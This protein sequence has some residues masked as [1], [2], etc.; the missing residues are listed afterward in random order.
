MLYGLLMFLLVAPGCTEKGSDDNPGEQGSSVIAPSG[1]DVARRACVFRTGFRMP[2]QS[3]VDRY[4]VVWEAPGKDSSDSMPTGNG[5]IGLNVWVEEDGDLLFYVGKTDA[6]SENGRLL[7][8]GRVRVRLTPNPFV[9]GAAFKQELRLR[10]GEIAI[11]GGEGDKMVFVRVWADANHPVVH[12]EARGESPFDMQVGLET[13]RNEARELKDKESHSA[14]G[15]LGGP[16]PVIVEPDVIMAGQ[17]NRIVWYHRN[18]RSLW[19]DNMSLQSLNHLT[20]TLSDPLLH[21]TFGAAIEGEG[22]RSVD[23]KTLR[24]ARAAKTFA[25]AVYPLT[26]QADSVAQWVERLD[27]QVKEIKRLDRRMSRAAHR[28]WWDRYWQR[29]WIYARGSK[30]AEA[31]TR[32][33]ALQRYINACQGRGAQ[34]IKFNGGIFNVDLAKPIPRKKLPAGL[35]ADF[36]PWGGCYW[37]QN[38][39][40]PY[41]AMLASGDFDLMQPL[42][43]MYR[44]ALPLARERTKTW[45]DHEGVFFPETMHFWGMHCNSNYGWDR[46]GKPDGLTDNTFIRYYWQGGLEFS[47]MLLDYFD[48]TQDMGFAQ[49]TMMPLVSEVITFYDQHWKRDESGKI[50]FDPAGALETYHSAVNPLPEI[51]GIEQVAKRL[52]A[53]P[54]SLTTDTQ[55]KQWRRLIEE[56]PAVPMRELDGQKVLD[57][58]ESFE[59]KLRNDENIGLYAIFPYRMYGL[60]KP[61]FDLAKRS[62]THRMCRK[63]GGYEY[64]GVMAACVGVTEDAVENVVT[65]FTSKHHDFRF[66]AFWSSTY[67]D[68]IPDQPQGGVTMTTLQL[69]LMQ[70]QG[71]KIMLLPAWP[72]E[73]DV[74]FKLYAPYQTVV[75]GKYSNGK[76]FVTKVQPQ[77]R[78]GDLVSPVYEMECSQ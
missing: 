31:V 3:P 15:L 53:L 8:L 55:C 25:V 20:E 36:R 64:S 21:R 27:E 2:S 75:E 68:W 24:S 13:W 38:T 50:R 58:A 7:K 9:K 51:V 30:D 40:W 22:L 46:T 76:I 61:D 78:E 37:W 19:P 67:Y 59:A 63:I 42:F 11:A 17:E 6:W 74:E 56:L 57:A 72:R 10:A 39:R 47:M 77:Q 48:L 52:L 71:K 16:K 29:S 32:G 33:Y 4:N 28:G 18:E 49:D 66:P 54:A 73:W 12:V 70:A 26:L 43:S 35:D 1:K 41:W 5:D 23:S 65:N 62:Y 60:A 34:P 14:Y 45:Y 44:D 69:M